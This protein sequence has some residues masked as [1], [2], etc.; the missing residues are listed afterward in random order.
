[1]SYYASQLDVAVLAG[2]SRS[3]VTRVL[4]GSASRWR[5]P[6]K[7]Q[8]RVWAAAR[9]LGYRRAETTRFVKVKPVVIPV[10]SGPQWVAII[11]GESSPSSSLANLPSQEAALNTVGLASRLVALSGDDTVVRNRIASLLSTKPAGILCCPS[12]FS[13]VTPLVGEVCRVVPL[14]PWA[15]NQL[16]HPPRHCLTSSPTRKVLP[17]PA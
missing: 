2:V 5:I 12:L 10:P 6:L 1:M 9:Q 16:L 14:S 13:R 11:I 15:A 17:V 4:S 8:E 3:T 7:T